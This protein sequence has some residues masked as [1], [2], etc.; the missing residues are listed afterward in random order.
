MH[1]LYHF[2][3]YDL[4][5][6]SYIAFYL[7]MWYS[8]KPYELAGA[9]SSV[10]WVQSNRLCV[11]LLFSWFSKKEDPPK[12][13]KPSGDRQP[14]GSK[15]KGGSNSYAVIDLNLCSWERYRCFESP[16]VSGYNMP[17]DDWLRRCRWTVHFV[18]E[19]DNLCRHLDT[20]FIPF[21]LSFSYLSCSRS[22]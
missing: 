10:N 3:F 16:T 7:A 14:E 9:L 17:T 5:S 2:L 4:H 15:D 12:P 6:H 11:G 19:A 13:P 22:L 8:N 20:A 1:S 21:S 18:D